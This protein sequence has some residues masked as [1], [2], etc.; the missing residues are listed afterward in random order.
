[1]AFPGCQEASDVLGKS[2]RRRADLGVDKLAKRSVR[3]KS[4][5]GG[6]RILQ[7]AFEPQSA[8]GS[9]SASL[10]AVY[11]PTSGGG[12]PGALIGLGEDYAVSGVLIIMALIGL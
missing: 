7:A 4:A 3:G 11:R 12:E 10:L 8:P 9:A 6:R 1:M 5:S 2:D